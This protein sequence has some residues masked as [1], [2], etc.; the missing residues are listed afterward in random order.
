[1][2][3]K[4][5]KPAIYSFSS[6]DM[7]TWQM[8][9]LIGEFKEL[10]W[11]WVDINELAEIIGLP[12]ENL[13]FVYFEIKSGKVF[14]PYH[15]KLYG[16]LALS[17]AVNWHTD[18]LGYRYEIMYFKK[19]ILFSDSDHKVC[20]QILEKDV[21]VPAGWALAVLELTEN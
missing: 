17:L 4:K 8:V 12:A 20:K 3:P 11:G 9:E 19:D 15:R 13:L 16:K 10:T 5:V 2:R 1:M 14:H 18:Y 7:V 6:E 21:F